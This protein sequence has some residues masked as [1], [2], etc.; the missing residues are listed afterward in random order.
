MR[1]NV[2]VERGKKGGTPGKDAASI[3]QW[4]RAHAVESGRSGANPRPFSYSTWE[5]GHVTS[6]DVSFH[7]CNMKLI[8]LSCKG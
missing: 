8:V 7:F 2:P 6:G 3:A 4:L 5:S 1:K